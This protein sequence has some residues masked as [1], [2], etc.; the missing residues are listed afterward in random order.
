MFFLFMQIVE[1]ISGGAGWIGAGLLGAVLS[2]LLLVHLPNKDK[3]TR[4]LLDRH[5]ASQRDLQKTFSDSIDKT[6]EHCKEEL[7]IIAGR[8]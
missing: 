1:P 5:D 6:I 4:D 3:Q 8:K 7:A 2:W